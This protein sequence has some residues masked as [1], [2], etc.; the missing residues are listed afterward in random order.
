MQSQKAILNKKNALNNSKIHLIHNQRNKD[1]TKSHN[2][3][4]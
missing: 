3:L 1:S 4:L 2:K